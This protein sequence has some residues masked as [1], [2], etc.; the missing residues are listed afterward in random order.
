MLLDYT[1][2]SI[3][4]LIYMYNIFHDICR[5]T[6]DRGWLLVQICGSLLRYLIALSNLLRS[7]LPLDELV[8]LIMSNG[9]C[10]LCMLFFCRLGS[11]V[12]KSEKGLANRDEKPCKR[13]L[14]FLSRT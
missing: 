5:W 11:L 12:K 8:L 6:T 1:L 7:S 13:L 3:R 9:S 2:N 4:D 14:N 10:N